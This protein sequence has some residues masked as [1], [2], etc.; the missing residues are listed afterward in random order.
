[1]RDIPDPERAML[2]VDA[3]HDT[4]ETSSQ[5]PRSAPES[6]NAALIDGDSRPVKHA[7]C[8]HDPAEFDAPAPENVVPYGYFRASS[9]E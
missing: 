5:L 8:D 1:M 9:Q 4:S 7:R 3:V 6:S 2:S